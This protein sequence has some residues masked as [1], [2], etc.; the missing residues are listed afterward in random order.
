MKNIDDDE[1]LFDSLFNK[2]QEGSI[3]LLFSFNNCNYVALIN[4]KIINI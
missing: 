2:K 4:S 1:L 3:S